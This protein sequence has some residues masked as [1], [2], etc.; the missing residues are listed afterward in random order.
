MLALRQKIIQK[1]TQ[2]YKDMWNVNTVTLGGLGMVPGFFA[3]HRF[4]H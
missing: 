4:L 1:K 2:Q 3:I